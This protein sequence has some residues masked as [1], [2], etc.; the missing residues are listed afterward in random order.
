[1]VSISIQLLDITAKKRTQIQF[2]QAMRESS[3]ELNDKNKPVN[4]LYDE[5]GMSVKNIPNVDVIDLHNV[6]KRDYLLNNK[7]FDFGYDDHWNEF[8]HTVVSRVLT[9]KIRNLGF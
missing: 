3:R 2:K 6:F 4:I 5:L 7:K 9:D 8:G 1:M